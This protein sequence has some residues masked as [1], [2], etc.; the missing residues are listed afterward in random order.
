MG[1]IIGILLIVAAAYVVYNFAIGRPVTVTLEVPPKGFAYV[2]VG[3]SQDVRC[4]LAGPNGHTYEV[5]PS[6]LND[7]LNPKTTASG[8][9]NSCLN[10]RVHNHDSFCAGN[11]LLVKNPSE[12]EPLTATVTL[13]CTPGHQI[14]MQDGEI[15]P[16]FTDSAPMG[17]AP[18]VKKP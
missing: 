5:T 2:R 4:D 17:N 1:I 9:E 11:Y 14:A 15:A 10:R 13:R 16:G 7:F 6:Q 8:C 12:N 18:V 3:K